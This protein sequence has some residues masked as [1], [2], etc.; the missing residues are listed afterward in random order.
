VFPDGPVR[1]DEIVSRLAAL[2]AA[3]PADSTE[4]SWLEVRRGQES[5]GKRRRDSYEVHERT[6]M[7][8]VR[9]AGRTGVHRTSLSLPSDL[10]NA[11]RDALAAARLAPPTPEPQS[12]PDYDAPTAISGLFDPELESMTPGRARDL[13]QRLSGRGETAR[14]G[15]AEGRVAVANSKGLRRAQ[16]V[17]SSWLEVICGRGPGAGRAT[18]ASRSFAGLDPAGVF[19]RARRHQAPLEVV[20]PPAAPCPAVFAPEAVAT[21]VELLNRNALTSESCR[22]G[23]S[24]LFANLGQPVFDPKIT[25][26]DDPTD[27]RGLPFPFDLLGSAAGPVDLVE[28]GVARSCAVDDGIALETGRPTTPNLIAPGEAVPTHL[29]LLPGDASEDQLLALADGGLWIAALDPVECYD[30]HALKFRA[31]A[32]GV[33]LIRGGGLGLGVPDLILEGD[34]PQ[35]FGKVLAVGADLNRIATGSGLF[36]A[37]TTPALAIAGLTGYRILVD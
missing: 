34:L 2:L 13:L 37:T 9:V 8:R 14:I 6:V 5:N 19:E 20:P 16:K 29:F 4:A 10:E 32:R 15:W 22:A 3:S 36:R 23:V 17:T 35:L 26:R 24:Y 12:P 30:A 18:G 25:L 27:A 7:L 1:L 31:T 11:L 33:R 21:L 28:G